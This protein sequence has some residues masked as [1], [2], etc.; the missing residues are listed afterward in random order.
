MKIGYVVTYGFLGILL[1]GCFALE[2][3]EGD[4]SGRQYTSKSFSIPAGSSETLSFHVNTRGTISASVATR[5][6]AS[7]AEGSD[8]MELALQSPSGA[9]LIQNEGNPHEKLTLKYRVPRSAQEGLWKVTLKNNSQRAVSGTLKVYYPFE[10]TAATSGGGST[11]SSGEDASGGNTS[12]QSGSSQDD[13]NTAQDQGSMT[14]GSTSQGGGEEPQYQDSGSGSTASNQ[15]SSNQGSVNDQ[16]TAQTPPQQGGNTKSPILVYRPRVIT[17][18]STPVQYGLVTNTFDLDMKDKRDKFYFHVRRPGT[19]DVYA[20]WRGEKRLSLILNGPSQTAALTRKD[21]MGYVHLVYN[22]KQKDIV[23]GKMWK[24]TIVNFAD[25]RPT[26]NLGRDIGSVIPIK[27]NIEI[28]YP[29][30]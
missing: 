9:D 21:G 5:G 1:A 14:Q 15:G 23:A 2:D 26:G 7:S 4:L 16:T 13:M 12:A 17:V 3:L 6:L 19:I 18:P 27:G 8:S 29:K 25:T 28:R 24:A 11:S 10:D 30:N 22:V 20:R